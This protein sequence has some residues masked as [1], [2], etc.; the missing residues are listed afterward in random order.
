MV[1]PVTVTPADFMSG[2]ALLDEMLREAERLA[3]WGDDAALGNSVFIASDAREGQQLTLYLKP[4]VERLVARP[5]LVE[6]FAAALGD[7]FGMLQQGMPTA[8]GDQYSCLTYDDIIGRREMN[9]G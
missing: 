6:G 2:V 4:L 7:Y 3:C 8:I 5:E 1:N 9:H